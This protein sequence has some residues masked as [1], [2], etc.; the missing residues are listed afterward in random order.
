MTV[1]SYVAAI[2]TKMNYC[3]CMKIIETDD[4]KIALNTGILFNLVMLTGI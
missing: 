2:F 1:I 3:F 4:L